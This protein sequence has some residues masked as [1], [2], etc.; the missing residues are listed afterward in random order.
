MKGLW[1]IFLIK[2][3]KLYLW[4]RTHFLIEWFVA[5]KIIHRQLKIEM[6]VLGR[7]RW[8]NLRGGEDFFNLSY[9]VD[10]DREGTFEWGSCVEM[11]MKVGQIQDRRRKM[12]WVWMLEKAKYDLKSV[13]GKR[14]WVNPKDEINIELL[15][16]R[17]F[18]KHFPILII[19]VLL[20]LKPLPLLVSHQWRRS[21][22]HRFGCR[23][24]E[25]D[26]RGEI[27]DEHWQKNLAKR[28]ALNKALSTMVNLNAF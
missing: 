15:T 11:P 17:E 28:H 19:F 10:R 18:A 22:P 9:V 13:E 12:S 5:Y 27:S 20:P 4:A 16:S 1:Y 7:W 25:N 14:R 24:A 23:R 26:F 8:Q 21:R 2:V 3:C 6:V